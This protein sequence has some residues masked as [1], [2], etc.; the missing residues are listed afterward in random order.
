MR[1]R[2]LSISRSS[3]VP[4]AVP[5]AK[6]HR[7]PSFPN[8]LHFTQIPI[9]IR[10][11]R[12]IVGCGAY[13]AA[14]PWLRQRLVY[15]P[16]GD[17]AGNQPNGRPPRVGAGLQGF[18]ERVD[19]GTEVP[20][21]AVLYSGFIRAPPRG[22]SAPW[23][24]SSARRGR[25]WSRRLVRSSRTLAGVAACLG[26]AV[27]FSPGQPWAVSPGR[28]EHRVNRSD[29]RSRRTRRDRWTPEPGDPVP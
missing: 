20:P 3:S 29:E 14:R 13:R 6:E 11:S 8:S 19:G 2:A 25:H 23:R 24:S 16:A 21:L 18:V 9:F 7:M 12:R 10:R 5:A 22:L 28:Q 17:P 4:A 15:G 27:R 1:Y 26:V